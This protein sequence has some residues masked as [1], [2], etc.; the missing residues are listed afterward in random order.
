MYPICC[1]SLAPLKVLMC[2]LLNEL[3]NQHYS[4]VKVGWYV[5]AGSLSGLA[6]TQTPSTFTEASFYALP[7][8]K[9]TTLH[10]AYIEQFGSS[11]YKIAQYYLQR[12]E[13]Y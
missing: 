8:D 7:F 1:L 2:N 3:R 6:Q 10:N 13:A 5:G 12:N 11:V 4:E 9:E